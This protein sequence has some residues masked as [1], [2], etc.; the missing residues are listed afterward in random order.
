MDKLRM[1]SP[2]LT[3]ANIEKLAE[4]FPSV[5]TESVDADGNLVRAINFDLLR[6]ELSFP[7]RLACCPVGCGH[8]DADDVAPWGLAA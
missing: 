4:I 7:R 5:I 3:A 8:V 1:T 6:Q 2:D